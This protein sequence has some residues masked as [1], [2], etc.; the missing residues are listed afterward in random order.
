[1][2]VDQRINEPWT[3]KH[4]EPGVPLLHTSKILYPKSLK[5]LIK[6]CRDRREGDFFKAAGSHWALSEVA[7]SDRT[8]VETHDLNHNFS[9]MDRTLYEVIPNGLTEEFL[10]LLGSIHLKPFDAPDLSENEGFKRSIRSEY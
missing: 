10:T 3:R 5:R 6:I 7:I 2:A 1:M 4:D 8:F 9:A